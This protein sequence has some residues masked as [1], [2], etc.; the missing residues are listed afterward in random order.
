LKKRHLQLKNGN[1]LPFCGHFLAALP[2]ATLPFGVNI[3]LR[4]PQVVGKQVGT[5]TA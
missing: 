3:S 2:L 1:L 4:T 5:V